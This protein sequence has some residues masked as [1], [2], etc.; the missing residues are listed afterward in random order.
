MSFYQAQALAA[1]AARMARAVLKPDRSVVPPLVA[2]MVEHA[3]LAP[4]V[5]RLRLRRRREGGRA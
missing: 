5:A 2:F 1:S 3:A 4:L